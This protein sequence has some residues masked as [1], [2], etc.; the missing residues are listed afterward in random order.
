MSRIAVFGGTF[1]PPH[2]GH[3]AIAG[4]IVRQRMADEVWLMVSPENPFKQGRRITPEWMRVEMAERAVASLPEEV[5][6]RVR[7][8]DFEARLPKPTY[9]V[10]TLR[11]L[12]KAYPD[13]EFVL[14]IGEDN[15]RSF[16]GWRG[17]EEILHDYGVIVYPREE[18]VSARPGSG[19]KDGPDPSAPE[20]GEDTLS[21]TPSGCVILKG[22]S[23]VD[24]SSTA[25]R[26]AFADGRVPDTALIPAAVS[27]YIISHALYRRGI[28]SALS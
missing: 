23:M 2:R 25:L 16:A 4:A 28:H 12:R 20:E 17:P 22:V 14:V 10:T 19:K 7:V 6:S 26:E 1:D 24:V 21:K 8:S 5:R 18:G 13:D 9:T 27:G 3:L 15:L 11:A